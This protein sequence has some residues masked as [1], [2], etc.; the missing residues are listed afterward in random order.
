MNDDTDLL[1]SGIIDSFGFLELV[2]HLEQETGVSFDFS[3]ITPD[4][5]TTLGA[6]KQ[7]IAQAQPE[8]IA[9]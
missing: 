1:E 2:M 5:L 7:H 4:Q 3:E 9:S 8:S 6:L